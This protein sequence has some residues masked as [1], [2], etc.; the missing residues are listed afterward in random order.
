MAKPGD[1]ST[2]RGR[3][4]LL[5]EDEVLV[6][7]EL[8]SVLGEQGC[9]VVGP[10][11]TVARAIALIGQGGP[12][13]ALLDLNLGGQST[14]PVAAALNAHGVPFLIVSGYSETQMQAPELSRAPRLAK[15]VDHQKL[16]SQL[17]RLLA[18]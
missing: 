10:A 4:V 9:V 17:T 2:L 18:S 5:V 8:E 13:A 7:M 16:L 14:L 11:P 3:R 6:A 15:P 1:D 12:E